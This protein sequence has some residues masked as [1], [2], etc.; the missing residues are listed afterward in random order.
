MAR[1]DSKTTCTACGETV[2][3]DRVGDDGRCVNCIVL[4]K[5]ADDFEDDGGGAPSGE[6]SETAAAA[7]ARKRPASRR[8]R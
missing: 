8:R 6:D 3:A 5:T 2:R 1:D 7:P 4:D